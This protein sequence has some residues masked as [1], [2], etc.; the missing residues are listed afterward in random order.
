MQIN[1]QG[2]NRSNSL[3]AFLMSLVR[4]CCTAVNTWKTD[5]GF[6]VGDVFFLN[7]TYINSFF[8]FSWPVLETKLIHL[9]SFQSFCSY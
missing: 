2:N 1:G 5:K 7:F 3:F 6:F 8:F 4:K 9:S